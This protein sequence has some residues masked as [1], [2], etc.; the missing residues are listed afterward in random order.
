MLKPYWVVF[1]DDFGK[2]F[3]SGIVLAESMDEAKEYVNEFVIGNQVVEVKQCEIYEFTLDFINS[4]F[5][6]GG[7]ALYEELEDQIGGEDFNNGRFFN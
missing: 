3:S 6:E 4:Y 2:E 1:E 7:V 5:S